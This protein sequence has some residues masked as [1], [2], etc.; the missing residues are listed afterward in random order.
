MTSPPP[1][2]EDHY[3]PCEVHGEIDADECGCEADHYENGTEIKPVEVL[4]DE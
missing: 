1:R 3:G 2:P 4:L